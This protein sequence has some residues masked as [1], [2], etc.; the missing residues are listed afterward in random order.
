MPLVWFCQGTWQTLPQR[1]QLTAPHPTQI[2]ACS[3]DGEGGGHSPIRPVSKLWLI[4]SFSWL[5]ITP[6]TVL[7]QCASVVP[8]LGKHWYRWANDIGIMERAQ[9]WMSKLWDLICGASVPGES[10][11]GA[12]YENHYFNPSLFDINRMNKCFCSR[13]NLEGIHPNANENE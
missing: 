9:H 12:A 5:S 6:N 8:R 2:R 4:K 7:C 10:H 3:T 13:L 1:Y 11:S